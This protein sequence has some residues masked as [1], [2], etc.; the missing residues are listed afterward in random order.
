MYPLEN[1]FILYSSGTP[2]TKSGCIL[3]YKNTFF[4]GN[5]ET[6]TIAQN[7]ENAFSDAVLMSR[8]QKIVAGAAKEQLHSA[9]FFETAL[10]TVSIN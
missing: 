7:P 3:V 8:Y 6:K 10:C 5:S 4:W 1:K 2:L 9:Q